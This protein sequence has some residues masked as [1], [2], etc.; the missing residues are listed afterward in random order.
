M[1]IYAQERTLTSK[2]KG[3]Y[4]EHTQRGPRCPF[5]KVDLRNRIF[6]LILPPPPI[7]G[8][9]MALCLKGAVTVPVLRIPI[10]SWARREVWRVCG[11]ES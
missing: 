2:L 1:G 8:S 9:L 4:L 6:S 7:L 3:I 5:Q 11:Q 10:T